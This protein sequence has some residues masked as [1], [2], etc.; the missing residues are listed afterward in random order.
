MQGVGV[1]VW[2]GGHRGRGQ[3]WVRGGVLEGAAGCGRC[4][5]EGRRAPGRAW[6]RGC[7]QA[8]RLAAAAGGWRHGCVRPGAARRPLCPCQRAAPAA[9][10]PHCCGQQ[11]PAARAPTLNTTC[12]MMLSMV[13]GEVLLLRLRSSQ[14]SD[15]GL[16]SVRSSASPTSHVMNSRPCSPKSCARVWA[17]VEAGCQGERAR[18]AAAIARPSRGRGAVGPGWLRR[19]RAGRAPLLLAA[20]CMLLLGCCGPPQAAAAGGSPAAAAPSCCGPPTARPAPQ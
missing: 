5:A 13:E 10:P 2:G 1:C 17:G 16:A 9:T 12:L 11:H 4:R 3:G 7:G 20:P 19:C 14:P 18:R 8:A 6:E 15:V